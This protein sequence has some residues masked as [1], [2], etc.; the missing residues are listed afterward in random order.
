M[1]LNPPVIDNY[2]L[3]FV[4]FFFYEPLTSASMDS[5]IVAINTSRVAGLFGHV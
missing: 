2:H 4:F 3:S 1:T 5:Y